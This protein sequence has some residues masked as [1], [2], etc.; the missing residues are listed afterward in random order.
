MKNFVKNKTD[1]GYLI[2]ESLALK[3]QKESIE[4]VNNIINLMKKYNKNTR[5]ILL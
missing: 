5:I 1:G 2:K 3:L 4:Y